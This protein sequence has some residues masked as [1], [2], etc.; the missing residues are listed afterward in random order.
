MTSYHPFVDIVLINPGG[1][2]TAYHRARF[3]KG[4]TAH[5][6]IPA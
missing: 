3:G 2:Q 5:T 4:F 6:S 1:T